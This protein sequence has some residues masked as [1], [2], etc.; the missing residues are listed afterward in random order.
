LS[1]LSIFFSSHETTRNIQLLRLFRAVKLLRLVKLIRT[2]EGF[3][4]L[5]IMVTALGASAW[6]LCWSILLLLSILTFAAL[7]TTEAFRLAYFEEPS[8]LS[9]DAKLGLFKY[10]GTFSRSL[11]SLFE[12]ALANW[13]V[14]CRWLMENLHEGFMIFAL[15]FKLGMG[16]AVIGVINAVFM[17]ETFRVASTDDN[18][19]VRT[20]RRA[21]NMHKGKMENLFVIADA[22]GSGR[23]HR[24]EFKAVLAHKSIATW[25]ASM[26]MDLG[27]ADMLFDLLKGEDDMIDVDELIKGMGRLKGAA[28]S[29]DMRILLSKM[30]DRRVGAGGLESR[31]PSLRRA[32]TPDDP[33]KS[34][35]RSL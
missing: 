25:L 5:H 2:I 20:K 15:F 29:L 6:A 35:V 16:V 21:L 10:F 33:G 12:L 18:I 23:I 1:D 24:G 31:T 3:D 8:S 4:S 28:R 32:S 22:D 27:D 9:E 14:I 11:I 26:D 19:M 13:P 17:Q 7:I 30:D 34:N